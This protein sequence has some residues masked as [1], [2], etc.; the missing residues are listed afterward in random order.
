MPV[1]ST[2]SDLFLAAAS[3]SPAGGEAIGANLDNYLR[4]HA[5]I[6]KS[7]ASI[8]SSTIASAATTNIASSDG[9][10]VTVTG[11]TTI[12]SLGTGFAGCYRE[13]Q[14]S[15]AL[16]LTHSAALILP[17]AANITTVAND[18]Y[19]FRCLSAGNWILVSGSRTSLAS[20]TFTGNGNPA[21]PAGYAVSASGSFGGG[22]RLID[23]ADQAGLYTSF[24]V[25]RIAL[26]NSSSLTDKVEINTTGLK[27]GSG[28]TISQVTLSSAAPGALANGVLYLRY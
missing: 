20:P 18:V 23:G 27:I 12:T 26:G 1:P 22:V 19:A 5:S 15:G 14:F 8:S 7:T 11:T 10:Q 24:G 13:V 3:N 6:V 28:V 16:Q 9:E 17:G 4:A 25:L 21:A 2:M